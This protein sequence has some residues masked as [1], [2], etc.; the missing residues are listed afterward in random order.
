MLGMAIGVQM[1]RHP[2]IQRMLARIFFTDTG[3]YR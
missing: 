3:S 1:D 2:H